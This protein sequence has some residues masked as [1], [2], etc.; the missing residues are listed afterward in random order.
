[1]LQKVHPLRAQILKPLPWLSYYWTFTQS[2]F[3]TDLLFKDPQ[4]L[5]RLY[6]AFVL[7]GI[8][9]FQSPHV[10]RYLGHRVPVTT[11]RIDARF[12]GQVRSDLVSPHEGVCLKHLAGYNGIKTYDKLAQLLRVENTIVRPEAF[13]IYRPAFSIRS[14]ITSCVAE[15]KPQ[16]A[17]KPLLRTVTEIPR[18]A[19]VSRA[20]NH[21]Y[22]DALAS[23]HVS[24]QLAEA[25]APLCRP[26]TREGYRYRALH[27]FGK[28]AALLRALCQGQWVISGI[29]N[30]DL[31]SIL[32][33]A[34]P[35]DQKNL[36][37]ALVT[38]QNAST[39]K[40]TE[41]LTA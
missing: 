38:A 3:A 16:R 40:L 19:Q 5:A 2:E 15:P 35:R 17:W 10:M 4:Q 41:T 13:T 39:E 23:T 14:K 33:P 37:T 36:L 26:I 30:R 28:D 7:H 32:Y 11:G 31:Q 1:M 12:E 27:P 8:C 20:A 24:T 29:R 21:R 9:T 22:L 6:R 25:V 18:R 34:P